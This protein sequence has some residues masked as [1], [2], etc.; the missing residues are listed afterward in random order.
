[1][2]GNRKRV[3]TNMSEL[4]STSSTNSQEAQ[5]ASTSAVSAPVAGV[6]SDHSKSAKAFFA[7]ALTLVGTLP[8]SVGIGVACRSQPFEPGAVA[9]CSAHDETL[10]QDA[11]DPVH[12]ASRRQ[13][14]ADDRFRAGDFESALQLYQSKENADS[15]RPTAEV[16]LKIAAC[17][18]GLRQHA[19][20]LALLGSLA[21]EESLRI[22][23]AAL[24]ATARIQ[25]RD[26]EFDAVRATIGKL[27]GPQDRATTITSDTNC[28][29]NIMLVIAGLLTGSDNNQ[30]SDT[31]ELISALDD[32]LWLVPDILAP[33]SLREATGPHDNIE[34]ADL[35]RTES[36]F[37]SRQQ[38]A[39]EL[40]E[41]ILTEYPTHRLAGCLRLALG[42]QA[43]RNGDLPLAATRYG[44]A[45]DKTSSAK[46]VVAAFNQGV[47]QFGRRDYRTASLV[48]GRFIDGAPKHAL[49]QRAL[50]LRGRALLELGDGATAAF[51]FKRAADL[52]NTNDTQAWATVFLGL[53]YLQAH[54][55]QRAA[56]DLFQRRDRIQSK[57]AQTAAGFAVSLARLETLPPGDAF[58]RETLFMLRALAGLDLDADRLGAAGRLLV[59]RAYQRLQMFDQATQTFTQALREELS[60][61]LAS[62]MKL[63]L[64]DCLLAANDVVQA[65]HWLNDVRQNHPAPSCVTAGLRLAR[66]EL[67]RGDLRKCLKICHDLWRFESDRAALLQ[68]M[69]EA[70]ERAGQNELAAECFAGLATP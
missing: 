37:Q 34:L 19:D 57:S 49:C 29:A 62:E 28:D 46:S 1:M 13:S 21:D 11:T 35:R 20:A 54:Q 18:E 5:A 40:A 15:L 42:E 32:S 2:P 55:P 58:D 66:W 7:I 23:S 63:A 50:W 4:P 45:V 41:R 10:T 38:S 47:L 22:R 14:R 52:P 69:G 25:L 6:E 68:L 16:A 65:Q 8:L 64:A 26:R 27:L 12:E 3:K 48:L 39:E 31:A 9:A 56:R 61:P 53:A 60:E 17:R 36:L 44:D 24:I 43:Y 70:H 33:E 51:D 30:Y 67:G 59:G